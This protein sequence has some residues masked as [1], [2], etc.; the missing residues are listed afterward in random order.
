M[1]SRWRSEPDCDKDLE[2]GSGGKKGMGR[3]VGP[4]GV[5]RRDVNAGKRA[6][7][8]EWAGVGR[9]QAMM[10]SVRGRGS[11]RSGG[12]EHGVESVFTA[13]HEVQVRL[14]HMAQA[15]VKDDGQ[16]NVVERRVV[17]GGVAGADAARVAPV[18][19]GILDRQWPRFQARSCSGP[20]RSGVTE[21]MA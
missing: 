10:E 7:L 14:G 15:A 2:D 16:R 18:V 8:E 3:E 1:I 5:T 19:V 6:G 21:V 13:R 4:D 17:G 20:G 9:T 12:R 11:G